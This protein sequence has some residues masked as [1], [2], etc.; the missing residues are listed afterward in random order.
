MYVDLAE[1]AWLCTD[2]VS[3]YTA[4]GLQRTLVASSA[5][6][7]CLL[8]PLLPFAPLST[9]FVYHSGEFPYFLTWCFTS[10]FY[11][12]FKNQSIVGYNLRNLKRPTQKTEALLSITSS[13][14]E[15]V[16]LHAL[17]NALRR[18]CY[19]L[20]GLLPQSGVHTHWYKLVCIRLWEGNA[21]D[22]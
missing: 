2:S 16:R 15:A 5:P 13:T 18:R 6:R 10:Y 11:S 19:W 14:K 9:F 3:L 1:V 20:S 21:A 22:F 4:V 7:S 8:Y 12:C 17:G